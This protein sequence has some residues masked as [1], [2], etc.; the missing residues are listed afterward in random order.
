MVC[1]FVECIVVCVCWFF[2]CVIAYCVLSYIRVVCR[3]FLFFLGLFACAGVVAVLTSSMSVDASEVGLLL[4]RP[5]VSGI[6]SSCL[7]FS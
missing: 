6:L 3:V 1:R 5:F 7:P 4:L 2:L